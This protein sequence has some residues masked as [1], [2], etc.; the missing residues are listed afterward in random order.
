MPYDAVVETYG[1]IDSTGA[2]A[3][4]YGDVS[5]GVQN[6][7]QKHISNQE[8]TVEAAVSGNRE[9][10]LQVLLN[11]SLSSRLSIPQAKQ[12]LDELLEVNKQYLPKFVEKQP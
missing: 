2:H 8:M 6:I 9:I 4:T 5:V 1:G 3:I 7:L 10:A 12:M 11:D